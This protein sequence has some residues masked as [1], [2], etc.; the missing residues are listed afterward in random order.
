MLEDIRVSVGSV[1]A[2]DRLSQRAGLGVGDGDEGIEFDM[3]GRLMRNLLD[4][5]PNDTPN[6]ASNDMPETDWNR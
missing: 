1:E 4:E 3:V 6:N 5:T 2:E